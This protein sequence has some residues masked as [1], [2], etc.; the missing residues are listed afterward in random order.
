MN[1][2]SAELE[3]VFGVAPSEE[4]GLIIDTFDSAGF[5]GPRA[6]GSTRACGATHVGVTGG[7]SSGFCV[8][9]VSPCRASVPA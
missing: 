3:Q 6:C 8:F 5:G 9:S 7:S 2:F 4:T 1:D